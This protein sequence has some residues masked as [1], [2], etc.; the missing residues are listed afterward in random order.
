MREVY[1]GSV[2]DVASLREY[3]DGVKLWINELLLELGI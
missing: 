3:L 2:D 1:S